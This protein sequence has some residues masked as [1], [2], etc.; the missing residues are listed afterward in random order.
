MAFFWQVVLPGNLRWGEEG[1]TQPAAPATLQIG[2]WVPPKP[3]ST[4]AQ[5]LRAQLPAWGPAD[6][7]AASSCPT[8]ATA[9]IT[10][11]V[12]AVRYT[13]LGLLDLLAKAFRKMQNIPL[14]RLLVSP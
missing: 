13:G 10:P 3:P 12:A 14:P 1:N 6:T 7:S 5:Q 8:M 11:G 2:V 4:A 9:L